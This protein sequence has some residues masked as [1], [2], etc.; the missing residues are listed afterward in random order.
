MSSNNTNQT[1]KNPLN[2]KNADLNTYDPTLVPRPNPLHHSTYISDKG[3]DPNN[4]NAPASS[5][6]PPPFTHPTEE[7]TA[8]LAAIR[9]EANKHTPVT[10]GFLSDKELLTIIHNAK[11]T[12]F[13]GQERVIHEVVQLCA[14][15]HSVADVF[16]NALKALCLHG[17]LDAA[18]QSTLN[19]NV[20]KCIALAS[21]KKIEAEAS[22]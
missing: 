1:H 2:P 9:N 15:G 18:Q 21:G 19:E 3:S 11:A 4:D 5:L 7:S 16:I 8:I 10:S 20:G 13:N 17:A 6:S 22:A 12:L 14:Q